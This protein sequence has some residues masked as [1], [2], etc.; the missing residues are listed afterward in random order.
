VWES[1]QPRRPIASA[2]TLPPVP[3]PKP[4][5]QAGLPF[6]SFQDPRTSVTTGNP[7]PYG[8][9]YVEPAIV[10]PASASSPSH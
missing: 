4:V 9:A 3:F 6:V 2:T 1:A 5:A 10:Q 8:T 7:Y